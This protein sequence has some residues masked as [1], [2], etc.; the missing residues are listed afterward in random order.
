MY[1][2]LLK[3]IFVVQFIK[4]FELSMSIKEFNYTIT[5]SFSIVQS[6]WNYL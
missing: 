2:G 4:E 3:I 6:F 5:N 1:W